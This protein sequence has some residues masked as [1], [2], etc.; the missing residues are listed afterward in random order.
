MRGIM[1]CSMALTRRFVILM[2]SSRVTKDV[3]DL[4]DCSRSWLTC[5]EASS[6]RS[7]TALAH[8]SEH[9]RIFWPPFES[10]ASSN[11]AKFLWEWRLFPPPYQFLLRCRA[12]TRG[13]EHLRAIRPSDY[14]TLFVPATFSLAERI[15][16]FALSTFWTITCLG[17]ITGQGW[18]RDNSLPKVTGDKFWFGV[19]KVSLFQNLSDQCFVLIHVS[20]SCFSGWFVHTLIICFSTARNLRV[21]AS[22][23][24]LRRLCP[25]WAPLSRILICVRALDTKSK[26]EK[27]QSY[28]RLGK[29]L[30]LSFPD[31]LFREM[32]RVRSE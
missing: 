7:L 12:R 25:R 8:A 27:S 18:P 16:K 26:R 6:T 29:M 20:S 30:I 5:K 3:Y 4:K 19:E 21:N 1:T 11:P 23:F 9:C 24:F 2:T 13:V 28:I 31:I 17:D 32:K 14:L 15:F 10:P 22:D